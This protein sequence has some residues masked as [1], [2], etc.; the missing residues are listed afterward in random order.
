MEL[1]GVTVV[2]EVMPR[3]SLHYR[4]I[5]ADRRRERHLLFSPSS[6]FANWCRLLGVLLIERVQFHWETKQNIRQLKLVNCIG[7]CIKKNQKKDLVWTAFSCGGS[8][9]VFCFQFFCREKFFFDEKCSRCSI[10][11]SVQSHN[12]VGISRR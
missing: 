10:F 1:T 9:N 12:L 4:V 11:F 3:S 7:L 8:K 2:L 6:F 5:E